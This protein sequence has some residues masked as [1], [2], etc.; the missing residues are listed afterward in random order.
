MHT[1]TQHDS[2]ILMLSRNETSRFLTLPVMDLNI[3]HYN[4]MR[5]S[6]RD[7]Y[8]GNPKINL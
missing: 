4:K 5:L 3:L 8:V 2:S 6:L 1:T 7:F